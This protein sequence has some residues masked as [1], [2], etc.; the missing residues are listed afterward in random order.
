MKQISLKLNS[1]RELLSEEGV[2]ND[3]IRFCFSKTGSF[4][5]KKAIT[6]ITSTAINMT[7][8]FTM[9]PCWV[10]R[11]S[12]FWHLQDKNH[13][14]LYFAFVKI[15][16]CLEVFRKPHEIPRWSCNEINTG[17]LIRTRFLLGHLYLI[18][19]FLTSGLLLDED[20]HLNTFQPK[21]VSK[22]CWPFPDREGEI[23][24]LCFLL[25]KAKFR[26]KDES[27]SQEGEIVID[28]PL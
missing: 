20:C 17:S 21:S 25:L 24:F 10:S 16:G 15:W 19:P 6:T 5:L 1:E 27:L 13:S 8:F 9:L 7:A 22:K 2:L 28:L 26:L 11:H 3:P 23:F 14:S 12:L 4:S 18:P